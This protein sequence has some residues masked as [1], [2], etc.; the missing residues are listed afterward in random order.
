MVEDPGGVVV[1][2][3]GS[4]TYAGGFDAALVTILP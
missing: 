4:L 1:D 3:N 2:A